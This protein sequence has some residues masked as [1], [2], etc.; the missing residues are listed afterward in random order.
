MSKYDCLGSWTRALDTITCAYKFF[1]YFPR[2]IGC[3]ADSHASP[4]IS[5][6]LHASEALP[7]KWTNNQWCRAVASYLRVVWATS[8]ILCAYTARWVWW[9]PPQQNLFLNRRSEIDSEAVIG[10]NALTSWSLIVVPHPIVLWSQI[11]RSLAHTA[12]IY[13]RTRLQTRL[14][15]KK[16]QITPQV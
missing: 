12:A 5:V 14:Y 13:G 7:L 2:K 16:Y 10:Q 1:R 6:S 8:R 4:H 11:A 9:H 15:R 3:F